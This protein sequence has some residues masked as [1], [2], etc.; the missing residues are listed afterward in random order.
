MDI[1][2]FMTW[3]INQVVSIFTELFRI[4]QNIQFLGTNL[5]QVIVTIIIISSILPILLTIGNSNGGI[6]R[7]VNSYNERVKKAN[8]KEYNKAEGK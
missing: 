5:L 7:T 8:Q 1:S 3:F 4:L 2:N 6:F